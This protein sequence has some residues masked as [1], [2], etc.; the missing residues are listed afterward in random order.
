MEAQCVV[1]DF[2]LT[3]ASY[4]KK[5]FRH[6]NWEEIKKC[7]PSFEFCLG[8]VFFFFYIS[9]LVESRLGSLGAGVRIDSG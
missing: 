6:E 9:T 7:F 1:E 5:V 2:V 8:I 4:A 3:W